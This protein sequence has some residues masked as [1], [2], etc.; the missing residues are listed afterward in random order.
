MLLRIG[1]KCKP[2]FL[3]FLAREDNWMMCNGWNIPKLISHMKWD[4]ELHSET[5]LLHCHRSCFL[6][7]THLE[8]LWCWYLAL[9]FGGLFVG[10]L[11]FSKKIQFRNK[12]SV[13]LWTS[14]LSYSS[15]FSPCFMA[16]GYLEYWPTFPFISTRCFTALCFGQDVW[17][18]CSDQ[19][20]FCSQNRYWSC[21]TGIEHDGRSNAFPLEVDI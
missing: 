11:M 19:D 13:L 2:N 1:K 20:E 3:K 6:L 21:G 16:Y 15:M 8:K 18:R 5:L 17:T 12:L 4:S 14:V 7:P 10:R 9:H